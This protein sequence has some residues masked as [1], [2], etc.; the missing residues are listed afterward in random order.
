M[1]EHDTRPLD[2]KSRRGWYFLLFAALLVLIVIGG[3]TAWS[4]GSNRRLE[5]QIALYKAAGEPMELADFRGT[6]IDNDDDNA[7]VLLRE[8]AKIDT[9]TKAWETYERLN[10][11]GLPLRDKELE[12]IRAVV[13]ANPVAFEKVDA[14]MKCKGFDWQIVFTSPSISILLPDLS[15]QRA[16]ANLIASRAVLGAQQG[17]HAAALADLRRVLFIAGAVDHQPFLVCHMVANGI[18]ALAS[19]RALWIAPQLKI[20]SAAGDA[21]P[22]QAADFIA[23]LLDDK[24][25]RAAQHR[26]FQ[27]ERMFELDTV[28]CLAEGR[29]NLWQLGAGVAGGAGANPGQ[30]AAMAVAGVALKPMMLQ[31]GLIMMRHVTAVIAALDA[32]PDWPTFRA[33]APAFPVPMD[34][35]F[36]HTLARMLLPSFDRATQSDF[37]VMTD[38]RLAAVTLAARW[39]AVDHGGKL[40]QTLDELVPKYLPAVPMDAMAMKRPLQFIPDPTK[41]IVYS[42]GENGADDGG[43]EAFMK[44][45]MNRK[46]AGR[47][48]QRDA[49]AHLTPQP[50]PPAEEEEEDPATPPS[51]EPTTE[52][53]TGPAPPP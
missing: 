36:T 25:Q 28:R 35:R 33:R 22:R 49:V 1:S 12:R 5:R 40:P 23:E 39:Y 47:W 45:S 30:G 19:E 10:V 2:R 3:W 43:S 8:A 11:D 16:L 6:P 18:R 53:S 34:A 32:S 50:R 42:V 27:G 52:P 21:S 17:D 38:R 7:A 44:P 24:A 9:K 20:G 13:A 46:T 26:A 15:P 4:G 14:A 41:P 31:D 37:R 51:T 48:Q 29:M